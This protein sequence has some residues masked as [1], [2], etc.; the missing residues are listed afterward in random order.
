M[1]LLKNEDPETRQRYLRVS[2]ANLETTDQ[3]LDVISGVLGLRVHRQLVLKP[4]IQSIFLRGDFEPVSSFVGPACEMLEGLSQ[5][6]ET[7]TQLKKILDSVT[8]S[9]EKTLCDSGA[10]LHW[11]LRAWREPDSIAKFMYLFI[12]LEA[13]L[14]STNQLAI[15]SKADLD[16]IEAIVQESA[17]PNKLDLVSF[18]TRART[19]FGPTLNARFEEFARNEAIPGWELDVKAF[20]KYN[21]MRNLLLHAGNKNVREHINFDEHT[22]TLEDL[23]ERYVAVS[24]LDTADVYSSKWRPSRTVQNHT[25]KNPSV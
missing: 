9:S 7:E 5:S 17:A 6:A 25:R 24:L 1:G 20:K 12:P 16:C 11:L 21:S 3:L 19:R 14:P 4:L 10:I 8:V 2:D 22:R 18:L 23:V 13:V 15:E